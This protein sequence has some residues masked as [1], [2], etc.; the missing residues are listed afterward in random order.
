MNKLQFSTNIQASKE[1]VWNILWQDETYGMWTSVFSEG[2]KAVTDWNE[3]S[4]VLFMDSKGSGMFSMIEKKI[5]N[6]YMAFK[7]LGE[8]KDGQEL[9][10]TAKTSEWSGSMETYTLKETD[11]ITELTVEL[12]AT[13]EFADYFKEV[14]PKAV[15]KIKSLS[16]N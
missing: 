13:E 6:E 3:G 9:P 7:H 16:E 10:P 8:L 1:K 4:K 11:G 5:P 15:E 2:S 12:D 14:F